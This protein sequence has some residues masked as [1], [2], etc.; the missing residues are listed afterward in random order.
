ML[1]PEYTYFTG[2]A[3]CGMMDW[4]REKR[5]ILWN[6]DKEERKI[7]MSQSVIEETQAPPVGAEET[8]K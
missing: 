8:H 5:S 7:T 3:L 1:P 4:L 2:Y 6:R